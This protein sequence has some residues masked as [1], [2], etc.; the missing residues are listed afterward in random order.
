MDN[1]QQNLLFSH[2]LKEFMNTQTAIEA[3]RRSI[4]MRE[5]R[6]CPSSIVLRDYMMDSV[7]ECGFR[8]G[9]REIPIDEAF[10]LQ[11]CGFTMVSSD[12]RIMDW[13]DAFEIR[14]VMNSL[15]ISKTEGVTISMTNL[16]DLIIPGS[17][18]SVEIKVKFLTED[19][20]RLTF[21]YINLVLVG[22]RFWGVRTF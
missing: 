4:Y 15:M 9:I 13:A 10:V 8:L 12:H 17:S 1:K 2:N 5:C 16:G 6:L 18:G 21:S 11:A 7:L 14:I 20:R 19:M 22:V 3:M